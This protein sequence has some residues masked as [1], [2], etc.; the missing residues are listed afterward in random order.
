MLLE[1]NKGRNYSSEV[2]GGG[3]S[4]S[5]VYLF[6]KEILRSPGAKKRG[7]VRKENKLIL[8]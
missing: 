7:K 5:L 8:A 2:G 1:K 4:D 3:E 6:P